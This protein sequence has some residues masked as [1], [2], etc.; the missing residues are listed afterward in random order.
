MYTVERGK[1]KG[2]L[3]VIRFKVLFIPIVARYFNELSPVQ[4]LGFPWLSFNNQ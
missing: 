4:S 3:N 1:E 2:D